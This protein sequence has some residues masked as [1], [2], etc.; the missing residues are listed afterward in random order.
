MPRFRVQFQVRS[1][2]LVMLTTVFGLSVSSLVAQDSKPAQST[3]A[4]Q[5]AT[6]EKKTEQTGEAKKAEEAKADEAKEEEEE[7][8]VERDPFAELLEQIAIMQA[9]MQ[10]LRLQLAQ[11]NLERNEAIRQLDELQ[12]FIE[13]HD[14]LG[15]AYKEY[16]GVKEIAEREARQRELEIRRAEYERERA[17]RK[18]RYNQARAERMAERAEEQRMAGY[19]KAGFA[20]VG[21]DVYTSRMSYYY[22]TSDTTRRRIDWEDDI[23]HY[24]R[25]YPSSQI[26]FSK[27]TISGSIINA[28]DTT[29][30]VGIAII[31]FDERDTQVGHQIVQIN[32]ARPDVPY[33]FTSEVQ[34]ALNRPFTSS[35]TYVLYAD[36]IDGEGATPTTSE[37]NGTNGG[38]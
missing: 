4:S 5:A 1:F 8:P 25:L 35:S 14:Q 37:S 33:P 22:F 11:A 24:L 6:V 23:G 31:F 12:I 3:E 26:D 28:A 36:P 13:D 9:Q 18:A 20:G 16:R 15:S 17:A 34:M 30:N 2:L 38:Y 32:N 10:D 7:A 27:M 19:D 21:L 29:R